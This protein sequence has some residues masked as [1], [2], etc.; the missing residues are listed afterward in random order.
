MKDIAIIGA[1]LSGLVAARQL[2]NMA[3]VTIFEKSKGVGGRIATRRSG[4]YSFD[5][6]AQFFT[7]K[8]KLFKEFLKPIILEGHV[9]RW[10]GAFAEIINKKIIF[11]RKWDASPP[12]YVGVPSMNSFA[13]QLSMGADIRQNTL[14]NSVTRKDKRWQISDANEKLLGEYDWVIVSTPPDQAL[15]LLPQFPTLCGELVTRKM[16]SCFSIMLGFDS[17]LSLPFDAAVPLGEDISWISVNS[18]KPDR[19]QAYCLLIHSTNDWADQHFANDRNAV[20]EHLLEETSNILDRDLNSASHRAIHGWRF[21]NI[22]RQEGES[23]FLD[24]IHNLV[25]CGDWCIKGRIEAAFTSGYKAARAIE[26]RLF[27]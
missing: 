19:G 7:P 21:A 12:H 24:V 4:P 25:L 16:Q 26:T 10:D 18:S 11:K 5:H 14:V 22:D 9:K 8:T 20:L 2:G 1:G 3:N 13:K 17:D 6:G 15:Q 27:D 23:Y